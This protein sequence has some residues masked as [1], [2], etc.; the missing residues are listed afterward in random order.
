MENKIIPSEKVLDST[1]SFLQDGYDF[2]GKRCEKLQTDI[3]QTRLMAM[4]V[5]CLSGREAA[6]LFYDNRYFKRKGASPVRVQNTLFG[7]KGVQT[8]DD[9]K[10]RQRKEMFMSLMNREQLD[11]LVTITREQWIAEVL[12]WEKMDRITVMEASRDLMC[13]IACRWSGVQISAGDIPKRGREFWLMVDA[14]GGIGLRHRK[15]KTARSSSEKWLMK[16]ISKIRNGTMS[17]I[18][19]AAAHTISLY[20]ENGKLLDLRTAA[21]ELINI[22]R[23]TVAISY[24]ITFAALALHSYP[25]YRKLIQTGG[26]EYAL[27]FTQEVRRFYPFAPLVGARVRTDFTWNGYKFP[28]GRLVLLDIYGTNHDR[29]IWDDP[30][31][32]RPERFKNR[33]E[34]EFDFIP[35]G[36]GNHYTGHRCAGE[37][38][39][40]ETMKVAVEMLANMEYD[41]P[42]QDLDIDMTRMPTFPNSHFIIRNVKVPRRVS[43]LA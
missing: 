27:W 19:G 41:I 40:V 18:P 26:P 1:F 37:W 4:P 34:G 6:S 22:L 38:V 17:A 21:V 11:K 42:E 7:R 31:E 25:Q 35:Q 10:H 36:G 20:R 16:H 32:F 12:K 43:E 2:I 29:R 15:G 24:F 33:E 23:P 9:Q 28:K 39:T 13:R 30:D 3:F 8:L 14:F 5:I